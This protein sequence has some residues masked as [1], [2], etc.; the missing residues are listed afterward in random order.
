M[1]LFPVLAVGEGAFFLSAGFALRDGSALV[2]LTLA[3][4]Q[5]ELELGVAALEVEPEC[6]DG[7]A[8]LGRAPQ[9]PADLAAMQEELSRAARV[10]VVAAGGV[11]GADV[12][13]VD[14]GLVALDG[15]VGVS[16]VHPVGAN[17]LDLGAGEDDA[18]VEG[19]EDVVVVARTAVVGNGVLVGHWR[20]AQ[21]ADYRLG[22]DMGSSNAAILLSAA[23]RM[24]HIVTHLV[25]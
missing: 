11:V 18:G 6:D 8:A 23:T 3:A 17:R 20:P 13:V 1:R 4:G 12:H 16:K 24:W 19:L 14:P 7:E 10:E 2:V 25:W 22:R 15:D 9:Q 21:V 5:T